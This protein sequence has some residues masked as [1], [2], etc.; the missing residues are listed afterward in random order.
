MKS[1]IPFLLMVFVGLGFTHSAKSQAVQTIKSLEQQY[2]G[3]FRINPKSEGL[4]GTPFLFDNPPLGT[5]RLIDGKDYSEIPINILLEKNEVYIQPNGEDSDPFLVRNWDW[6]KIQGAEERNFKL[7]YLQ[8]KPQVVEF[9]YEKD[10]E[11]YIA[12]HKKTLIRPSGQR[13]GYSGPQ[14]DTFRHDIK[15]FK[16]KGMQETEI[17]TNSAGLKEW[18]GSRNDE[19]KEYIKEHKIDLKDPVD[20]KKIISFI[21]N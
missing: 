11:K 10:G 14:Y 9:L 21:V 5:I 16:L 8:G 18:A 2:L 20:M 6:V 13:D 1:A 17:K 4:I 15:Y 3:T 12:F 19:L 7:E